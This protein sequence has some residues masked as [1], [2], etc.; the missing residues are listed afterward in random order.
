MINVVDKL[1]DIYYKRLESQVSNDTKIQ[2]LICFLH[3]LKQNLMQQL[4]LCENCKF[5]IQYI[6]E[7]LQ[8]IEQ[9]NL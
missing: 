3:G 8:R 4:D 2:V 7:C 6:D 9:W 5:T 1:Q